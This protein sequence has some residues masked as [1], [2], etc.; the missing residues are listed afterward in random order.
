[1]NAPPESQATSDDEADAETVNLQRYP[2]DTL[3]ISA[4]RIFAA[5]IESQSFLGASKRLGLAPSTISKQ[6]ESLER[7]LGSLLIMRTT[8]QLSVT[9]AGV[10]FYNHCRKALETLDE[11][12]ASISGKRVELEGSLRVVAPPSFSAAILSPCLP[13]F[14]ERHP[15]LAV[16]VLVR[17]DFVDLVK[18]GV[19]VAIALDDEHRNKLP[20]LLVGSNRTRIC[21]SPEYL[22]R[23]GTPRYPSDILSH[24]CL[25]GIGT[26]YDDRWPFKV[27][28]EIQRLAVKR[29]LTTNNGDLIKSCCLSGQ[30]L[31]ALYAFHVKEEI[32]SGALVEVLSDFNAGI[33]A[34]YARVPNKNFIS[35]HGRVF[36][37]FLSDYLPKNSAP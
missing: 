13:I 8:R 33:S 12:S 29:V 22:K 2:I 15:K 14:M 37:D 11:G 16:E 36:L 32:E 24:R 6:V 19:D 27:N 7:K 28:S 34:L 3:Q 26:Q 4:L 30:G 35:P 1:M 21:A 31:A 18:E 5:V 25:A 20:I 10:N 23:H 9:E 17:S